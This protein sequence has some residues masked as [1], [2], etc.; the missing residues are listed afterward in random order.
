MRLAPIPR[1]I[2]RPRPKAEARSTRCRL[3]RHIGARILNVGYGKSLCEQI[4]QPTG[5]WIIRES[6]RLSALLYAGQFLVLQSGGVGLLMPRIYHVG[7]ARL[8]SLG[9]C[10]RAFLRRPEALC[11]K[12]PN[13]CRDQPNGNELHI[14]IRQKPG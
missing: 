6:R 7:F 1:Q 14:P 2:K 10:N 12:S 8:I 5:Q 13:T 9:S 11:S 4:G 3:C